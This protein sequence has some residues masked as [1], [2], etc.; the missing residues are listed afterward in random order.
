MKAI[1]CALDKK[2]F[3][4]V[5]CCSNSY[6]IQRKLEVVYEE[7]NQAKEFKI[8]RYARQYKLF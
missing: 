5:S 6:E 2:K 8:G 4:R 3:D 7:I 1:V